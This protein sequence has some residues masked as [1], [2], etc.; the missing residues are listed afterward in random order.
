MISASRN[1]E[2]IKISNVKND[3]NVV[4]KAN[5]AGNKLV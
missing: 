4:T 3:K 2:L 5:D 1:D